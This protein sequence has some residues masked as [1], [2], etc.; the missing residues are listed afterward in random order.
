MTIPS[1]EGRGCAR[2]TAAASAGH[3]VRISAAI[4]LVS[5]GTGCLEHS[6]KH[7]LVDA[8]S[9]KPEPRLVGNWEL[10]TYDVPR[11]LTIEVDPTRAGRLLM[12]LDKVALAAQSLTLGERRFLWIG[13]GD[14]A[15]YGYGWLIEYEH[16]E[17]GPPSA[18]LLD[19]EEC[20]RAIRAKEAVGSFDY[21]G[22]GWWLL[23]WLWCKGEPVLNL[24]AEKTRRW[25]ETRKANVVGSPRSLGQRL[26]KLVAD[27]TPINAAIHPRGDLALEP[28]QCDPKL[29][30]VSVVRRPES[31]GGRYTVEATD[32]PAVL[33][34]SMPDDSDFGEPAGLLATEID[35]VSY[36]TTPDGPV[37]DGER[38]YLFFRYE[39][40]DDDTLVVI[41]ADGDRLDRA[42]QAKELSGTA[43][44]I[45]WPGHTDWLVTSSTED[46]RAFFSKRGAECFPDREVA[47]LVFNFKRL[48]A[49]P[50]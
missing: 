49:T 5:A 50:R 44:K 7:P 29:L 46:V 28:G 39:F 1:P 3:W 25:L 19:P 12:T 20:S 38:Q 26:S 34:W 21:S 4:L 9:A 35:G 13:S 11:R 16:T 14:A 42:V 41:P 37:G 22:T 18:Q 15:A 43:K 40:V 23:P 36:L 17:N 32:D 47:P 48:P 27:Q 8:G 30:G 10:E 45:R 2:A 33:L 6:F 24:D 31:D